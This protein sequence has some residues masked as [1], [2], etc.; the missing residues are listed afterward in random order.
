MKTIIILAALT[1]LISLSH[2]Q[3]VDDTW[4]FDYQSS[5]YSAHQVERSDDCLRCEESETVTVFDYQESS[6]RFLEVEGDAD[7]IFD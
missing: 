6:F 7:S 4:V 2:A 1:L 5:T 3:D